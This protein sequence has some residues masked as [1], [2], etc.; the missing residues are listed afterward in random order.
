VNDDTCPRTKRSASEFARLV[1][2]H[3]DPSPVETALCGAPIA[4]RYR[5]RRSLAP[6]VTH[7][8]QPSPSCGTPAAV[9]RPENRR[10]LSVT[11][12]RSLSGLGCTLTFRSPRLCQ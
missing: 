11:C 2:L 3:A 12:P 7:A 9:V 8:D 4:L 1:P 10:S 6:G 5:P